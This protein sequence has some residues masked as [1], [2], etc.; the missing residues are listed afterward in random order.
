MTHYDN[1]TPKEKAGYIML[2]RE[3]LL[4]AERKKINLELSKLRGSESILVE[5]QKVIEVQ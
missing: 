4:N 5:N 2:C 1:Q 3:N